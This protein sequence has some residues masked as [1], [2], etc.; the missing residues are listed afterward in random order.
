[1]IEFLY[2]FF[3]RHG[4]V[5]ELVLSTAL[6]VLP[7]KRRN[8]FLLRVL[9][10]LLV[11]ILVSF[12]WNYL[13]N[14]V[15]TPQ[16]VPIYVPMIRYNIFFVL[17]CVAIYFCFDRSLVASL[18]V[19]IAGF[20]TQ[21]GAYKLGEMVMRSLDGLVVPEICNLLYVVTE[22]GVYAL[23]YFLFG[24]KFKY[25]EKEYLENK[26]IIYLSIALMMYTTMFQ[27]SN[28]LELGS[29]LVYA[30]YDVLCSIFTLAL[31][32]GILHSGK[33][34]H[35]YKVMEH[36]RHLE[37]TQYDLSK[38]NVELL[39]I[40]YHDLKH[41]ISE[42]GNIPYDDKYELERAISIYDTTIKT[43]SEVLDVILTEKSMFCDQK[44][45]RFERIA[46]GKLLSFMSNSDVYSLFGNAIDNAVEAVTMLNDP[47]RRVVT[48]MVRETRGMVL[49]HIENFYDGDIE[50]D[51]GL[52]V[53]TKENKLYHGYGVKSIRNIVNKYNGDFFIRAEDGVFRL[54]IL[55]PL[56][57][58]A[59]KSNVER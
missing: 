51:D 40:K 1:M 53:T 22:F 42:M 43:G 23:V 35:E 52:P 19:G 33:I 34:Q 14:S 20:S 48:L 24:R 26:Q 25:V 32:Y 45:V 18:F 10:T 36:L 27:Y 21:H 29:Y 41:M 31:Q 37:K 7:F 2:S 58:T 54:D 55:F 38:K 3:I 6:F 16:T 57:E 13:E 15:F 59:K 8:Y 44:G 11:F 39:N 46:D 50:F 4:Y 30:F 12:F 9:G 47:E 56:S 28:R 49:I 17:I 5:L